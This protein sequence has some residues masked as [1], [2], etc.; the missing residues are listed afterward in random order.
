MCLW[1]TDSKVATFLGK[2]QGMV[3]QSEKTCGEQYG[4]KELVK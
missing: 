2:N 4:K 1:K 3:L